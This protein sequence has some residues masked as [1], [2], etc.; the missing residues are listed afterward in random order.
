MEVRNKGLEDKAM[1][2]QLRAFEESSVRRVLWRR[3]VVLANRAIRASMTA[4]CLSSIRVLWS[5]QLSTCG[6]LE[7]T[8]V[9]DRRASCQRSDVGQAGY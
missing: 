6:I 9:K 2:R 8:G 3:V 4:R 1:A 5:L 7:S